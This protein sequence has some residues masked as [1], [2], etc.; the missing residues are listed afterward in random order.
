MLEPPSEAAVQCSALLD[1]LVDRFKARAIASASASEG[2]G[3][4]VAHDRAQRYAGDRI[5]TGGF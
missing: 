1:T 4:G 3:G 2:K 5:G